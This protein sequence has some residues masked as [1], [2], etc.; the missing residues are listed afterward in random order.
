ME[1]AGSLGHSEPRP[2]RSP[3]NPPLESLLPAPLAGWRGFGGPSEKETE[4]E[5]PMAGNRLSPIRTLCSCTSLSLTETL[6]LF[7]FT[8]TTQCKILKQRRNN[9][10]G[11]IPSLRHLLALSSQR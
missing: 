2:L 8:R 6:Y 7:S 5:G 9:T 1:G 3:E 10:V 4:T 11:L